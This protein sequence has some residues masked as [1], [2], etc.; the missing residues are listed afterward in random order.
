MTISKKP[1]LFLVGPSEGGPSLDDLMALFRKLTGRE[2]T[3][4]DLVKARETLAKK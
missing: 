3:E 2:P 1:E 4:E